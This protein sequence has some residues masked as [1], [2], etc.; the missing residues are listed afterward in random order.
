MKFFFTALA[1]SSVGYYGVFSGRIEEQVAL[2]LTCGAWNVA[3]V[4]LIWNDRTQSKHIMRENF[5][6]KLTLAVFRNSCARANTESGNGI[7]KAREWR[8]MVEALHMTDYIDCLPPV[9]KKK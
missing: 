8:Q 2:A 4:H 6:L 5:L 9:L 3:F 7:I 1:V